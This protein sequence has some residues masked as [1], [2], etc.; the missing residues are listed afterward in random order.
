[1][2]LKTWSFNPTVLKKDITRFAPVWGLYSVFT[3]LF[4]LLLWESEREAARFV[5]NAPE[6]FLAMGMVNFFYAPIVAFCL[7]GDL[8]RTRMAGFLHAL[9]LRREDWF[10]THLMAGMLFC[11][12]PNGVAALICAALLGE[13]AWVAFLWLGLMLLQYL[14]FFGVAT[15]GCL[16][17]GNP[18]GAAGIYGLVN[19]LAVIIGWLVITFYQPLLYGMR[20]EF[21]HFAEYSPVV[22]FSGANYLGFAYDNMHSAAIFEG[23]IPEDWR[24]LGISAAIGAAL[25]WVSLVIYRQRHVE[26]AGDLIAFRPAAPVVLAIYTL[27]VGAVLYFIADAIS[28]SLGIIFLIVGLAIGFFTGQMLLERRVKVFRGKNFLIFGISLAVFY[29]T[30]GITALDPTGITRR[31]PDADSVAAVTICPSHYF[32]DYDRSSVTL[33]DE[34]GIR[35]V[36]TIHEACVEDRYGEQFDR[37]PL[38]ISYEMK[39]GIRMTRYYYILQ[40]SQ[41]VATLERYFSAEEAVFGGISPDQVLSGLRMLELY[42]YRYDVPRIAIATHGDYLDTS[43]YDEKYGYLDLCESYLTED[44]ASDPVLTGLFHAIKADCQAGNMAQGGYWDKGDPVANITL[45]YH[46]GFTTDYLDIT[47][48]SGCEN[49][50]SFLDTLKAE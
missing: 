1:M 17:A 50:V 44:P 30:L 41:A 14:F 10:M 48:Y 25:L 33:M 16:C 20:L 3:L 15:F 34:T 11:I 13:F 37:I 24:Y 43:Y 2:K 32:Y 47:I 28:E 42:D 26:R 39:S 21:A 49:T 35:D 40:D 22:R 46:N 7:F 38:C 31:V 4:L 45:R 18:L 6:L 27:C 19:F 12:L 5:C 29:A 8:H 36:I 23:F 9:P